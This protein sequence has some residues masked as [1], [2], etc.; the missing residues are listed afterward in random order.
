MARATQLTGLESF[1]QDN[2]T[3]HYIPPSSPDYTSARTVYN[4][5]RT[6]NPLAIVQPQSHSD[7][8]ALIKYA[9]R[10][11]LPFTLRSGGH[12]LEGRA[13][14]ENALLIDLRA[15]TGV[16]IAPDRKSATIQGGTL[17]GEVGNT[18]WNAGLG[19]SIGL[20]PSVGYVGWAVYGGYGPFSAHWGLGVDQIIGATVVNPN[21]EIINADDALMEGIRGAGGLYGVILE[22]VVKVYPISKLLA[23]PII[24]DSNDIHK[25]FVEYNA[26]YRKLEAEDIPAELTLQQTIFNGP[27]GRAFAVRFVWSGDDL[28]EGQY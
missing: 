5:S 4:A 27:R 1:I 3:I 23:G 12:N 11:S 2:P 21:G 20:I 24:F 6:D 16:T 22:L 15:L 17:Q 8:C 9:K 13:V 14:V 10:K 25:T 7:V 19:T 18:L 28:D 26:E